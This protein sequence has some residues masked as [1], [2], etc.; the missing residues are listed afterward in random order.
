MRSL[1]YVPA[2]S[3]RFIQK[4]PTVGADVIILD[5]EDSVPATAKDAARLAL[6]SSAEIAATQGAKIFARINRGA[7]A[8]RADI[9]A[10]CSAGAEG[11][12]I[13]KCSGAEYLHEIEAIAATVEARAARKSRLAFIP[14]IEDPGAVLEA[15][16]IAAASTRNIALTVGSEDLA[17]SMGARSTPEMLRF[18]KLLVHLAAKAEGL[19]SLGLLRSVADYKDL[20]A[21]AQAVKE[22]REH[23]FDGA[24]CV[25]PSVVRLLNEGFSPSKGEVAHA[26]ALVAESEKHALDGAGAFEFQGLMVDAPVIER[27]RRLLR[28]SDKSPELL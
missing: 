18:P 15:R 11:I 2:N 24:S 14:M 21:I 1:L 9:E 3:P 12:L 13:A 20:A 6:S 28:A 26:H 16:Q 8:A 27:A 22:A 7:V 25:H 17:T 5:L 4:A 19:A 10:A 23:G